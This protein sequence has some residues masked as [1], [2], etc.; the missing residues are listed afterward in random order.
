MVTVVVDV[1][2]QPSHSLP[3]LSTVCTRE[4]IEAE[5]VEHFFMFVDDALEMCHAILHRLQHQTEQ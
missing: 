2:Y 3:V 4:S 1:Y 5:N